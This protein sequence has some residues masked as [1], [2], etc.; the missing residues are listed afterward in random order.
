MTSQAR[1][2][3]EPFPSEIVDKQSVELVRFNVTEQQIAS[4]R[5]EF[6]GLAFS[7]P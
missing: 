6:S 4:L 7:D 2:L 1:N 5:T 3:T